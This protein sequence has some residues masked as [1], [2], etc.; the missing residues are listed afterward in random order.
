MGVLD[1]LDDELEQAET[2]ASADSRERRESSDV[3][4]SPFSMAYDLESYE[5]DDKTVDRMFSLLVAASNLM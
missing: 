3:D 1:R 2:G 5:L 4:I